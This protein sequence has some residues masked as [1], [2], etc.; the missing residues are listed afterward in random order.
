MSI[1]AIR[2][3]IADDA[4]EIRLLVRFALE[5]DD[6]FDVVGEAAD[7]VETLDVID[8]TDPDALLLD[9]AM[10]RM[11]GLEVLERL[12]ARPFPPPV[13]VFSGFSNSAVVDKAMALGASGYI[14][15]GDDLRLVPEILADAVARRRAS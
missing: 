11:D 2:V 6:R 9:L 14:N 4:G 8:E 10:P 5:R 12:H 3:V 1:D 15:K 13:V 7:G